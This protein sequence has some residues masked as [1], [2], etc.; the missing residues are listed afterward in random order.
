MDQFCPETVLLQDRQTLHG[1]SGEYVFERVKS[2]G[3]YYEESLLK[4]WYLPRAASFHVVYD[5]GANIGNHTVFFAKYGPTAKVYSFE[6]YP[7]NYSMLCR[8]TEENGFSSRVDTFELALGPREGTAQMS[9]QKPGNLGTAQLSETGDATVQVAALD[10]L[11]LP[12]PDFV[13]IDVE[14]LELE[15]LSGMKHILENASPLLWLET[16]PENAA[17]V[18]ELLQHYGFQ[19]ADVDL[20]QDNNLLFAKE[21]SGAAGPDLLGLLLAKAEEYRAAYWSE[22]SMSSKYEFERRKA[23]DLKRDLASMTSRFSYEQ[24]KAEG[25]KRDLAS[26]SSDFAREQGKAE[27]LRQQAL[28]LERQLAEEEA[29]S[30]K[31]ADSCRIYQDRTEYFKTLSGKRTSQFLYEQKKAAALEGKLRRY[32]ISKPY[33]VWRY[34]QEKKA[35][36][37]SRL[38]P[39]AQKL[40]YRLSVHPPLLKL[41]SGINK[42]LHIFPDTS[43]VIFYSPTAERVKGAEERDPVPGSSAQPVRLRPLREL[44]VAMIVDEFSYNSFRYEFQAFPLEP[45]N[46]RDV[47]EKNEIDLFFCESAWTGTDPD[48]RPWRGQIYGSINFPKENRTTLFEILDYCKAHKIPTAFWNKEDPTH[49]EDRVH[50]FVDTALH[51]D[52][53]FTTAEECVERY[54]KDYG[55]RSVHLLMF[56][57]QPRLFNPIERFKRSDAVIFA[58]SWYRQHPVRCREMSAI[59]DRI[60]E[61][62]LPLVIYDRQSENQDPNHEFPDQYKPYVRPRLRHDQMDQ[63]YK[64]SRIALNINTVTDSST[65]FARRVFELM[66]SNTLVLSNYSKGMETLFGDHVV[67]VDGSSKLELSDVEA[68]RAWCLNEVLTQHTYQRRFE[69][70]IQ[71]CGIPFLP[72]DPDITLVYRIRSLAEASLCAEHFQRVSWMN[73]SAVFLVDKDCPGDQL[74]SV[75]VSFHQG[76]VNVISEHYLESSGERL[77]IGT[78]YAAL[79]DT[80]MDPGFPKKAMLHWCYL[81][82]GTGI[83]DGQG[84]YTMEERASVINVIYPAAAFS[85]QEHGDTVYGI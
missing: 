59:L 12:F 70:L 41:F 10:E 49:Y 22:R 51:F 13:K 76:S 71:D 18:E 5:I 75:L 28:S 19:L 32:E 44:R 83:A 67:F 33:R 58:G 38:Y 84:R 65:M 63:A 31:L 82:E 66:S 45:D 60:L 50:D 1:Y 54:R 69:Q 79:A 53:I 55:H 9:V 6:P 68:K 48:R 73:K 40:Y 21:E 57:T 26:V 17:A 43:A 3:E 78:R 47:F 37:R 80:E 27:Q 85:L 42:L 4:R 77:E 72:D 56:A 20:S 62:G 35:G 39:F 7:P 24:K 74:R 46:W 64:G 36:F 15:V 29:R 34:Y 8:N 2:T 52:H 61:Q 25:L 23:E 81:P 11:G 14:G 16:S 30:L